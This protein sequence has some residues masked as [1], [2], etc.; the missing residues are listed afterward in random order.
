MIEIDQDGRKVAMDVIHDAAE[1]TVIVIIGDVCKYKD[2][3]LTVNFHD[4]ST[5]CVERSVI[6]VC[7]TI[8]LIFMI[9]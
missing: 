2:G 9:F 6:E 3:A 5:V 4:Y 7:I 8:L 1:K